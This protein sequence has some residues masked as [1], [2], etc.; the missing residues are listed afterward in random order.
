M[1]NLA[2]VLMNELRTPLM[3]IMNNIENV[4]SKIPALIDTYNIAKSNKLLVPIIDKYYLQNVTPYLKSTKKEIHSTILMINHMLMNLN[5]DQIKT[6]EQNLCSICECINEAL[7][8]YPFRSENIRDL[9]SF[10]SKQDF[11]F[12]GNKILLTHVFFNLIKNA[13]YHIK[14]VGKRYYQY[15][16]GRTSKY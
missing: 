1:R 15:K 8:R 14:L 6:Q 9:I 16:A 12:M 4:E 10:S 13:L 5:S 2:A 11:L 3:T 7:Q